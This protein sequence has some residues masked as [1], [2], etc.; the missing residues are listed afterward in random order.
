MD[1]QRPQDESRSPDEQVSTPDLI[2]RAGQEHEDWYRD[3]VEHCQDLLCVHDLQGRLLLVNPAP[4]RVLGYSVEELLQI[5]IGELIAPEFRDQIDTYLKEAARAGEAHGLMAVLTRA[6]E[7]RIW[8]YRSTLR[9]EGVASPV[10]RAVAR[11]VTEQKRADKRLREANQQLLA[12][13]QEREQTIRD[14]KLF[15]TLVDQSNDAIEVI[16]P[17]TLRFLDVNEKACRDLGYSREELLSLRVFDVEQSVDQSRRSEVKRQLQERG[18][19]IG[20]GIHRRKDGSTFPVEINITSVQLD[21]VYNV[22]VARDIT[23]RKRAEEK[24]REYEKAMEGLE[25]MIVVLDRDYRYVVA[26]RAFLKSRGLE[27]EQVLG[28]S[29][30]EM[31]NP[32]VF[33]GVV[34]ERLDECFRGK[35]VRYEKKYKYPLL[36][37]RDLSV[38]YF[39]IEGPNG[40]D[41]VACVL[42]DITERKQAQDAL[43]R[44]EENYRNFVAQSSE[45]IFRQDLD[46]PIPIDLSEDELVHRILYDSYMAEC[47]DAMVKMYGL[48]SV[49]DFLG[50]R[51]TETLDPNDPRNIELTREYIRSGFR[52]LER[53]SHETDVHGN[54]K[55]FRNSMIGIVENGMLVCTWGIQRDITEKIRLDEA[56]RKAEDALRQSEERF[57]VALKNSHITVFHQDRD[58][59]YVW[60]YNPH[61]YANLQVLGKTDDEIMGPERAASLNEFK[62]SVLESGVGVRQE[63]VVAY[64]DQKYALD[65]NI[66][67]LLDSN[68]TVIGITGS[69]IDI[70]KLRQLADRLQE[71]KNKL[72]QEKLYLEKE[73]HE[74]L[75]FREIIGESAAIKD[76][77]KQTRV[78]APLAAT[79]LLLGET[80]TG[81]ELIARSLHHLSPRHDK[82]FIKLNCAAVPAGLL[83]SE[84]FGHE[85]GA[86]TGAVSQKIGRMELAD[87]GTL[88]LDEIGELPLELQPK[89]LRVLQDQEFEHLGGV[90]TLR[91]DARIIAATNRDLMGLVLEK[92]FREDLFYRLNVFPIRLPTLRERRSDIPL[93]VNHF[94]RKHTARMNKRIE[95]VPEETLEALTNWDW[96]GNVRELE[97]LIERLVILNKG[98]VLILPPTELEAIQED[99][100]DGTLDG[101]SR[102]HIV[103]V[104]R[105]TNGVLS[106]PGGAAVRL[107]LKRTTLQ[108]MLKRLNIEPREYSRVPAPPS[109]S[110]N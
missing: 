93:L 34:K 69:S 85:K 75:G 2:R 97:N 11:D 100:S 3:L 54:P 41:R 15:R 71:Q 89:L 110:E 91:V 59:R 65:V 44:S 49:N 99:S 56:R 108:S 55:V 105:E 67:P 50:K 84:L 48:T 20:E 58:L 47:N 83:E 23:H 31:L 38:S 19:A 103:R 45:G 12:T 107:G 73:I 109:G 88:F 80:G 5:P 21:R 37:E 57:R 7:R 9:T 40:V 78:V 53:M 106:G 13:A 64:N 94:L 52:V 63:I 29:L 25:E 70:A 35:V 90:R 95:S 17:E 32:G 104:L 86:F 101:I 62:R 72:V 43:R 4:A 98:P 102:E 22:V 60:I 28:R 10:V 87:K 30:R 96:P 18:L 26:N 36:G 16:D 46:A 1:L 77:L 66:E 14:L 76:V 79:V 61:L 92:K 81:K 42:Q 51:L 8:E 6:G 27:K 74:E 24:L 39:P 33:E 82:N 68:G